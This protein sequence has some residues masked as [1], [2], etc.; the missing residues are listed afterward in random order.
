MNYTR[1]LINHI[2]MSPDDMVTAGF[3]PPWTGV[4]ELT[5]DGR[6]TVVTEHLVAR[7][8]D[9][10]R[11]VQLEPVRWDGRVAAWTIAQNR[12]LAFS[13]GL[14]GEQFRV[15][16]IEGHSVCLRT[17]LDLPGNPHGQDPMA[18][19][20]W[21]S[22]HLG[23]Q[24]GPQTARMP[25]AVALLMR[26]MLD[27][28]GTILVQRV[29][30]HPLGHALSTTETEA[31]LLQP[32]PRPCAL[33]WQYVPAGQTATSVIHNLLLRIL[34]SMYPQR[35]EQPRLVGRGVVKVGGRH[36]LV[37][38]FAPAAESQFIGIQ[39]FRAEDIQTPSGGP[40]LVTRECAT[41]DGTPWSKITQDSL[42]TLSRMPVA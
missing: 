18:H 13:L 34:P 15:M 11:V 38:V 36:M 40:G 7:N 29:A 20:F 31:W 17:R 22:L 28:S 9:D 33:P 30:E 2:A 6:G 3:E 5:L 8:A 41:L 21:T 35:L 10:V 14:D 25:R 23:P 4:R 42:R 26:N 32:T 1:A 12:E 24:V 27:D 39:S 19:T 16:C 37:D